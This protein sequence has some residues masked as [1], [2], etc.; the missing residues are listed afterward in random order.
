MGGVI[1]KEAYINFNAS[2]GMFVEDPAVKDGTIVKV[3]T[4]S[5]TGVKTLKAG[6][7]DFKGNLFRNAAQIASN[8]RAREMF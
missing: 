3:D 2:F 7:G 4:F 5:L 6:E 8:N 1:N